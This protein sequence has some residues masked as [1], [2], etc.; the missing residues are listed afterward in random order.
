MNP[1]ALDSCASSDS[2]S[3]SSRFIALTGLCQKRPAL[4]GTARERGVTEILNLPPAVR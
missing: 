1:S 2:T 4:L 3:R